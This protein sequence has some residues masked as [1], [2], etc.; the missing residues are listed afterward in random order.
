MPK[1]AE[2]FGI[3]SL[4]LYSLIDKYQLDDLKAG[5]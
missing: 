3:T 1:T 2:L 5:S 4:T